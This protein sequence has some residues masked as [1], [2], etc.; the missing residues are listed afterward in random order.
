M[1]RPRKSKRHV[2]PYVYCAKGRWFW[3]EYLGSGRFGREVRLGDADATDQEIW[4]AYLTTVGTGTKRGTVEHLFESFVASKEFAER[5]NKTQAEYRR[6]AKNICETKL[7]D[8]RRF[9]ELMAKRLTIP[10]IRKLMDKRGE[11]RPIAANRELEF[12]ST[13]YKWGIER[14]LAHIN[15]AAGV[16]AFRE[17]ARTRLVTDDEYRAVYERA[18]PYVKVAMEF[19]FLCRLRRVE[20]IGPDPKDIKRGEM[21]KVIGL[22]EQHIEKAG[23]RVIRAKGSKEQIIKWTQSL[24]DAVADARAL[25]GHNPDGYLVHDRNGNKLRK[26]AFRS[27]WVRAMKQAVK[28]DKIEPFTFHDLKAK[29]VSDFVG[30]KLKASGHKSARQ[31]EE[32]NRKLDQV[33]STR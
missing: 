21:P 2:P 27:A 8:G 6:Y 22:R 11:G 1:G 9:G 14:S 24:R 28:K 4:D 23:L 19:A 25:P 12:I 17:K 32:Y 15:P 13:A 31:A 16:T 30:D 18:N 26:T 33:K 5:A 3:R 10:S 7:K 20:I 29:G